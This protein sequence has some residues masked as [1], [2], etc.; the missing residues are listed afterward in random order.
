MPLFLRCL[1]D[2]KGC[3]LLDIHQPLLDQRF[4]TW[5]INAKN[6]RVSYHDCVQPSEIAAP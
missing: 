6:R 4:S 3:A 2:E 5:A 1:G